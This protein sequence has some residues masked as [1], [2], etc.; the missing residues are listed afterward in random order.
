MVLL[1]AWYTPSLS[2]KHQVGTLIIYL[3]LVRNIKERW[4]FEFRLI[5]MNGSSL[6]KKRRMILPLAF[7]KG[8]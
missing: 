1:I 5:S 7:Q 6:V 2:R 3:R 4:K 8:Q